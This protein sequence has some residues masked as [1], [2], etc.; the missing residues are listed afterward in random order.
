[1]SEIDTP[2]SPEIPST[3]GQIEGEPQKDGQEITASQP[4][5][6]V[7]KIAGEEFEINDKLAEALQ[8]RERMFDKKLSEKAE[9]LRRE[10]EKERAAPAVIPDA[11]PKAEDEI[12][13]TEFITN[14]T[15]AARK[16]RAKITAEVL[17]EITPAV[18]KAVTSEKEIDKVWD[19]FYQ[20]NKDLIPAKELV[21]RVIDENYGRL[22]NL[23]IIEAQKRI[24]E[25]TRH[26]IALYS[27]KAS[28]GI[29][30]G[31]ELNDTIV[32]VEGGSKFKSGA[33]PPLAKDESDDS[34]MTSMLKSRRLKRLK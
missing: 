2:V 10:K 33:A 26:K 28:E 30:D 22:K 32:F 25:L 11:T 14:P 15:E 31:N 3:E 24:A 27:G 7:V 1:M 17:K 8:K 5:I 34:S 20:D 21:T 19:K 12:D 13:D 29:D 18:K 6:R 23:N 4:S 9:E 16:L